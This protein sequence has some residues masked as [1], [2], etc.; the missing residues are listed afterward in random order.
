M[1]KVPEKRRD[2]MNDDAL[3]WAV[4]SLHGVPSGGTSG[5]C[6]RLQLD[7]EGANIR[8]LL[9]TLRNKVGHAQLVQVEDKRKRVEEATKP[10]EFH[11]VKTIC[12]LG[13]PGAGK[14]TLA[15][16]L[17]SHHS[18]TEQQ[19]QHRAFVSLSP[20][21]NL[22]DTLTD[23]LLQVGA[24]NDDATPYCG[25]GTPHQQYLIDNIS[26]YLIGKSKQSSL[27]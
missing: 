21:A 8:K 14:T 17:Y 10:C 25:T 15:K 6:S 18:T 7:G 4:S 22:T 11:E 5:D 1:V 3:H 27:E 13:L 26:A 23:I 12:I 19:F 9:S 16:L 2:D 20:G 24:Y